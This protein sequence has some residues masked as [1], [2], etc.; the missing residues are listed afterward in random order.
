VCK[1]QIINKSIDGDNVSLIAFGI[2]VA[3]STGYGT[4]LTFFDTL[5]AGG[6]AVGSGILLAANAPLVIDVTGGATNLLTG[7]P[8]LSLVASNGDST[9]DAVLKIQGVQDITP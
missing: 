8:I 6:S 3:A 2:D 4:R 1:Q 9:Y 5:N 7:S